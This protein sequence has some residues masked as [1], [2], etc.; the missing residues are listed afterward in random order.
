[1]RTVT[2]F[3]M[4]FAAV[5]ATNTRAADTTLVAQRTDRLDNGSC[6]VSACVVG[7]DTART[8]VRVPIAEHGD[9]VIGRGAT[10]RNAASN[11]EKSRVVSLVPF[12]SQSDGNEEPGIPA[13]LQPEGIGES[14]IDGTSEPA[15]PTLASD[16]T[17]AKV[18][19]ANLRGLGSASMNMLPTSSSA[20]LFA[21]Q[22]TIGSW[23]ERYEY[24]AAG[25]LRKVIFANGAA[26][27]YTLD[28][29]DN[30]TNVNSTVP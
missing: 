5:L 14:E 8:S 15:L 23:T 20:V 27:N 26:T 4:A 3:G 6:D 17:Q 25:R 19:A 16:Q 11:S 9:Y 10:G 12:E 28:N 29:A 1:M 22:S 30:R 18:L 21:L 7:D 24:D 2:I 13:Q